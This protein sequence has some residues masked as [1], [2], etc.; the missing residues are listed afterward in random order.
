MRKTLATVL[1]GTTLITA[2]CAKSADR[3]EYLASQEGTATAPEGAELAARRA[4]LPSPPKPEPATSAGSAA[5][6]A[7]TAVAANPTDKLAGPKGLAGKTDPAGGEAYHDWGK[8][9][10][11]DA[12]EGPPV[13]VRRRRRHRVVHDRA[14]QA[15]PRARCRRRPSV[16]VEEFV[17]Y[18]RYAFPTP[19]AGSPFSV[20]MDAAP[21]PLAPGRHIL[22]VGVATKAKSPSERKPAHLVFLVDVSGS[23]A[24]PDKLELAKQSL[25]I[26]TNNLKDGDT[27]ALVTYAGATRVVLPPTGLE[28]KARDPRRDR[29]PRAPAA[30]P[31]WRSG[32]D[33]AYAA[34]DAGPAAR[35]D[36]ARDRAAPTATPTS[37]RTRTTR[38]SRSSRAARRKA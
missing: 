36:L 32:I 6:A 34:G 35:R 27:V 38:S 30:R 8:N 12:V 29:R 25:R 21:S 19:A 24:S 18:F 11:I 2:A 16:R 22:R 17:N 20:V 4:D 31:R 5:G 23:M 13:D 37:A 10:W 33:L 9:P 7:S 3:A 14:P 28:H 1:L 26:L 15:A